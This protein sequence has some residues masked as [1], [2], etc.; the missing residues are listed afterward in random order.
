MIVS[1][2]RMG[3]ANRIARGEYQVDARKVADAILRRPEF[4]RVLAG[5]V[6]VAGKLDGGAVAP[7]QIHP[8]TG[9]DAA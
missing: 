7:T 1:V 8:Y 5:S 2:E 4:A 6:L 9:P 3:I